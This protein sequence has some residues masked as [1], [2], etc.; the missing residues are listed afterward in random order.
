MTEI[1]HYRQ[2]WSHRTP[3]ARLLLWAGW[4]ALVALFV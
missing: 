3:R 2:I 4:L 1:S